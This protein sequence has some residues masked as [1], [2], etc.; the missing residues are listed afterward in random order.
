MLVN[1]SQSRKPHSKRNTHTRP[2]WKRYLG[3]ST[4][5]IPAIHYS[6]YR[7][8]VTESSWPQNHRIVVVRPEWKV[9]KYDHLKHHKSGHQDNLRWSDMALKYLGFWS[10]QNEN[11]SN[12]FISLS[13]CPS[14]RLTNSEYLTHIMFISKMFE[15]CY[16]ISCLVDQL[17]G[18]SMIKIDGWS[19]HTS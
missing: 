17:I 18:S 9:R 19:H 2:E 3:H 6:K 8:V 13:I 4:G 7:R 10:I 15:S 12:Q 1:A 11:T 16:V 5:G 14:V